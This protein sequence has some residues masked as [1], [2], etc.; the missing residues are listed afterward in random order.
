[1]KLKLFFVR[2]DSVDGENQ[3]LLVRAPAAED[4]PAIWRTHFDLEDTDEPIYVGEVP[5][6][7]V[8][9]DATAGAIGWDSINPN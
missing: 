4:A 9:E 5:G 8:P 1:M 3:D 2:A 6:V 7:T